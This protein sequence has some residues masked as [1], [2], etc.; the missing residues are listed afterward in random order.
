MWWVHV[1]KKRKGTVGEGEG[2]RLLCFVK[3]N[4]KSYSKKKFLEWF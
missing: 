3:K 1:L 2:E 4:K